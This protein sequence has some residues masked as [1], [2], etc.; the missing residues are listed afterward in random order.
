M[1]DLSQLTKLHSFLGDDIFLRE[2]S[3]VKQV[4]LLYVDP[5]PQHLRWGFMLHFLKTDHPMLL[6]QKSSGPVHCLHR[7]T[8]WSF[9]SFW[10]R[11]TK[12]RSTHHPYLTC[13]WR[14]STSISDSFWTACMWSQCTTVSQPCSHQPPWRQKQPPGCR[15]RHP[16]PSSVPS[17]SPSFLGIKKDP[18]K[19][20]VP[21]T[22]IIGGKVSWVYSVG[23]RG[24]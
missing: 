20:F 3:N 7:R 5:F 23:T 9:L 2:I 4:R 10:R 1:K 21:R 15:S 19:L 14:G 17:T 8:S 11:S 18:K 22:V 24:L 13:M 12:W 6:S 16:R